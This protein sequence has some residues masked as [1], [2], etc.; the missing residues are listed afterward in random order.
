V[1]KKSPAV[2]LIWMY[3]GKNAAARRAEINAFDY[4]NY[5]IVEALAMFRPRRICASSGWMT[6]NQ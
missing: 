5:R 2:A 4:P 6:T 1:K 3:R